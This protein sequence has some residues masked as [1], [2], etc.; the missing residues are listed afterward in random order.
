MLRVATGLCSLHD[1]STG[2]VPVWRQPI[3]GGAERAGDRNSTGRFPT[4]AISTSAA[5]RSYHYRLSSVVLRPFV[6][7][8]NESILGAVAA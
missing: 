5:L 2:A 8:V 1:T 7:R 4:L 3:S 6:P